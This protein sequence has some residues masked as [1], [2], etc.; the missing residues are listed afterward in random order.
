MTYN[1][2]VSIIDY[3]L[4]HDH[5]REKR[6]ALGQRIDL[7]VY[8]WNHSIDISLQALL[9]YRR[10]EFDIYHN[11]PYSTHCV[12]LDN[13]FN[14]QAITTKWCSS[15]MRGIYHLGPYVN[16]IGCT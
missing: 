11:Y 4:Q 12:P 2:I 14:G 15:G 7:N 1:Q 5:E 6:V 3:W 13:A 8:T 16:L 9:K 10:R